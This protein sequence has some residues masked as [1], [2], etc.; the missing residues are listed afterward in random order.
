MVV[1][2]RIFQFAECGLRD[3]LGGDAEM[4][5]E[6]LDRR[7]GADR[8]HAHEGAVRADD[9]VPALPYG[10]LDRDPHGRGAEDGLPLGGPAAGGHRGR[11]HPDR[12]PRPCS[13]FCASTAMATSDPV[14]NSDTSAP[15]GAAPP[16][17]ATIS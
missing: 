15:P 13:S 11:Q 7:A 12:T 6:I 10:G 9:L 17:A 1:L 3:L 2:S 14:A 8:R 4:A 16:G 5:V